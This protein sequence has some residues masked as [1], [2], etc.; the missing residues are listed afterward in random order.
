M[1]STATI[2]VIAGAGKGGAVL[3]PDIIIQGSNLDGTFNS[4]LTDGADIPVVNTTPGIDNLGSLGGQLIWGNTDSTHH[5]FY[6]APNLWLRIL[7]TSGAVP[8]GFSFVDLPAWVGTDPWIIGVRL[9]VAPI[10]SSDMDIAQ[11]SSPAYEVWTKTSTGKVYYNASYSV[12]DAMELPLA[13]NTTTNVLFGY[14][15]TNR[16]LEV[17]GV[18]VNEAIAF[19]GPPLR[20]GG[21][22]SE[23]FVERYARAKYTPTA[24]AS[25][26]TFL[27]TPYP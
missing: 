4:S 7:R 1:I 2:G 20:L 12:P 3:A 25:M 10:F 13:I 9:Y 23:F 24:T 21:R 5:V 19:F 14:D 27:N 18:R 26:L 22:D 11:N 8:G 6:Y 15:G 16:F 17:G